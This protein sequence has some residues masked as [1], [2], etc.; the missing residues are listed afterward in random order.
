MVH[1]GGGGDD[2][3]AVRGSSILEETT[4]DQQEI[5]LVGL[6]VRGDREIDTKGT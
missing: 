3:R 5:L 4:V 1:R 6:G 2:G